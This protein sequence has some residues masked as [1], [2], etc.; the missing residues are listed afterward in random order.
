MAQAKTGDVVKVHYTG[1]LDDG[2][3]FDSS[4]NREPLEFKIGAGQLI[5][6]FEQAVSPPGLDSYPG[7]EVMTEHIKWVSVPMAFA[8]GTGRVRTGLPGLGSL[9]GGSRLSDRAAQASGTRLELGFSMA[10]MIGEPDTGMLVHGTTTG[11]RMISTEIELVDITPQPAGPRPDVPPFHINTF[12]HYI[13]HLM[14][15]LYQ[16]GVRRQWGSD[17]T[18]E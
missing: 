7:F 3:V 14:R 17:M 18:P 1:K 15:P 12:D 4:A 6:E 10:T 2:S 8:G 9:L 11:D 5:P 13:A 16:E